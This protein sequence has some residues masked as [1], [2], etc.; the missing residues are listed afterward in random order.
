M[1]KTKNLIIG[2]GLFG[3]SLADQLTRSGIDYHLIEA[4]DR[5]GGRIK[6]MVHEGVSFDLGPSWF[7][8]DQPRMAALARRFDTRIFDQYAKG[9]L[10][11]EDEQMRVMRNQGWASMEGALRLEG[12]MGV[13][14]K[15]LSDTLP[16]NSY[17]LSIAAARIEQMQSAVCV[18]DRAG[19]AVALAKRVIMAL[20]PRIASRL[21]FKPTLPLNTT[22]VLQSV[23]TWMAG[24]AKFVAVYN[25][26]FWRKAGFSGDAISRHGPMVEIH[27]A[28]DCN[29]SF[30]A[31]F[32]FLGIPASIRYQQ[33]TDIEQICIAQLARIFGDQAHETLTYQLQDWAFAK[34][35]ATDAD[36][37]LPTSHPHYGIEPALQDIWG[38]RVVFGS[39]EMAVKFGGFLEGALEA[40]EVTYLALSAERLAS[41]G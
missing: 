14:V 29:L 8:P 5:F 36:Q 13:L 18:Y 35:T 37:L 6:T 28:S 2:G 3:L 19:E 22:R 11:Y 39:T 15:N 17:S 12:G 20:P 4:R 34:H 21:I 26:P 16:P 30:G 41:A 9:S 32:G 1:I 38:G 7:W 24:H 23:P 27:D 40:A 31:L 25:T 10:S 33:R